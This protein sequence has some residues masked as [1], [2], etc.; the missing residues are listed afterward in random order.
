MDRLFLSLLIQPYCTDDVENQQAYSMAKAADEA[1]L[2]TI[3]VL[4]K[5]D[6]LDV[7]EHKKWLPLVL[8]SRSRNSR[9]LAN[10]YYVC[11]AEKELVELI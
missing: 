11:L 1:G 3:G 9:M 5:P 8:G 6:T 4:T 7:G 10:G 2:R